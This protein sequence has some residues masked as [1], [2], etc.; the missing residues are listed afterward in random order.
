MRAV[1]AALLACACCVLAASGLLHSP[2]TGDDDVITEDQRAGFEKCAEGLALIRVAKRWPNQFTLG[3][4]EIVYGMRL[5]GSDKFLSR[6]L[7]MAKIRML[8]DSWQFYLADFDGRVVV[9]TRFV[10]LEQL[11]LV[12]LN[13]VDENPTI[14]RAILEMA[15]RY[16]STIYPPVD[17]LAKNELV[18]DEN[19]GQPLQFVRCFVHYRKD[20]G[21]GILINAADDGYLYVDYSVDADGGDL[22]ILQAMQFE[23]HNF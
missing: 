9:T 15:R 17:E 7:C 3:Q 14:C 13:P 1:W 6:V 2:A 16:D 5:R 23:T 19:Y 21:E 8:D 11:R 18:F 20:A 12:D 10:T 4:V 22:F